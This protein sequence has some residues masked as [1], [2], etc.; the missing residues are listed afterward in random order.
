MAS[1]YTTNYGLCQWQPGDKFLREEFNQDNEK[2]DGAIKA[3]RDNAAA[4]IKT[5]GDRAAAEHQEVRRR[6]ETANYN[7]CNLLLQNDYE[8]KYTGFKRA[9]LFDGFL[10]E[11]GRELS[12]SQVLNG[13]SLILGRTGQGTVN[14]PYGSQSTRTSGVTEKKTA[15]GT[16]WATG[17]TFRV[18]TDVSMSGTEY[19]P[20]RFTRNGEDV[21]TGRYA[22]SGLGREQTREF[23]IVFPGRVG[24]RAGDLFTFTLEAPSTHFWLAGGDRA[25]SLAGTM[26]IAPASG[27][28]GTSGQT[29]SGL[30]ASDRVMAWVR[31]Q[32]GSVRLSLQREGEAI[33]SLPLTGQSPAVEPLNRKACT[34]SSFRLDRSLAAGQFHITLTAAL[35]EG[36]RRWKYSITAF[37]GSRY[38]KRSSGRTA[39]L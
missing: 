9:L 11:G 23:K 18:Y 19:L 28:S 22:L 1:N 24:L 8:G 38:R 10:T 7:L 32:S 20:Y 4:D 33:H 21:L 15:E 16:G 25:G 35:G 36:S 26:H 29:Q 17:F 39:T 2:L 14:Y 5:V 27:V 34:E 6:L 3:V 37:C 12:D 31:H 30:P 13:G